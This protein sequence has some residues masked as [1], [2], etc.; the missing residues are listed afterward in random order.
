MKNSKLQKEINSIAKL[1][2]ITGELFIEVDV[3]AENGLELEAK[4]EEILNSLVIPEGLE[5]SENLVYRK[6]LKIYIS[7]RKA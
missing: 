1:N 3:K 2:M 4:S 5:I 6:E 7:F